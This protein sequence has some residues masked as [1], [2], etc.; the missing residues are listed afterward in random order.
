MKHP[1]LFL[2][3]IHHLDWLLGCLPAPIDDLDCRFGRPASSPWQS[4]SLYHLILRC[5]DG[6]LVSYRGSYEAPVFG[7][8]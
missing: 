4:P 7:D 8:L 2:Q 6:V 3:G 1:L 5:R